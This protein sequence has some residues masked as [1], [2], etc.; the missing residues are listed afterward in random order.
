MDVQ[1]LYP[2][3]PRME[4]KDAVIKALEERTDKETEISTILEL[5][6]LVLENNYI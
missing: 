3:V 2:S 5:M 1:S 4:A 6:D